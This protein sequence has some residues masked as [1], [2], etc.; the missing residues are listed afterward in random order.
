MRHQSGVLHARLAA[1]A[2]RTYPVGMKYIL[3]VLSAA[4]AA[5]ALWHAAPLPPSPAGQAARI[6]LLVFWGLL[7]VS[8][9]VLAWRRLLTDPALLGLFSLGFLLMGGFVTVFN[10]IG[11][12]LSEPP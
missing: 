9:L 5:A 8:V 4:W 2:G 10:Y 12:R 3:V 1:A 11:F 6:A 7:T